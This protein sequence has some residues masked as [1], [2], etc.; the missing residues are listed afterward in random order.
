MGNQ[1]D[2]YDKLIQLTLSGRK[3]AYGEL[4]E[5]TI[6]DVYK[7]VHFLIEKKTD[8]DDVVQDIYIQAYQSLSRFDRSKSFR[9]W[10]MGIAVRQIRNYRRKTWTHLRILK[11]AE[12]HKQVIE[13]D[14]SNDVVDKL[15]NHELIS[16]IDSLPYKLKQVV[17]LR[18][19]NEHS[20]EEVAS[21]LDIP[22]GTVKSRINAA[23]KKLRQKGQDNNIFL[24]KVENI[25]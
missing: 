13:F 14:F 23:L 25:Q 22:V 9:P 7:S 18:Y 8:V 3:E 17:I 10:L 1:N 11:K 2:E 4:Y 21:I 15:S 16:L 6:R 5:K 12:G 24:R 20:Q 19:L